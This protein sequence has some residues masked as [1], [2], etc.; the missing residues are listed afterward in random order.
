MLADLPK[1]L[2]RQ[3]AKFCQPSN[4]QPTLGPNDHPTVFFTL[5]D[6]KVIKAATAEQVKEISQRVGDGQVVKM[7]AQGHGCN[8]KQSL[9]SWDKSS[10]QGFTL[11]QDG[12][13]SL[14][15]SQDQE[16]GDFGKLFGKKFRSQHSLIVFQGCF[17][18]QDNQKNLAKGTSEALP[19]VRVIGNVNEGWGWAHIFKT[20]QTDTTPPLAAGGYSTEAHEYYNDPTR[21]NQHARMVNCYEDQIIR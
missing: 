14:R 19:G 3:L 1:D 18:A 4:P 11:S 21:P 15:N 2:G 20:G 6:G 10:R 16:I 7:V 8:S 17:T 5:A 9:G 13:I 12:H